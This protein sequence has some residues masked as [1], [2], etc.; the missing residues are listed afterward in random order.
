MLTYYIQETRFKGLD[1]FH[2][3]KIYFKSS[4]SGPES[5]SYAVSQMKEVRFP[6]GDSVTHPIAGFAG[7]MLSRHPFGMMHLGRP[8]Q[9]YFVVS[10]GFY[11]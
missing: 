9:Q 2:H 5:V 3:P 4:V 11:N 7:P 6:S 1:F 10:I 8:K